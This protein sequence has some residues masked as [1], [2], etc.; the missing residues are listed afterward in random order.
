MMVALGSEAVTMDGVMPEKKY[1]PAQLNA[2]AVLANC[3]V[4]VGMESLSGISR[5]TCIVLEKKGL[6]MTKG[7]R[8]VRWALTARGQAGVED[9]LQRGLLV[10]E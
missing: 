6:V 9:L 8:L 4:E 7:V 1:S 10:S 5:Q 3:E 2:L